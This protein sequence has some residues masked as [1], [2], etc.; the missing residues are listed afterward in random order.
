[1]KETVL[2]LDD[3]DD[4]LLVFQHTFGAAYD[5]RVAST[6]GEARRMLAERPADIVISDQ[7]MPE[8]E[9]TDFLREVAEIYPQSLRALMTGSVHLG[10]V[11]PEV[12]AGIVQLFIA[13]PWTGQ[14]VQQ[15]LE[16]AIASCRLH[17]E[18]HS[19]GRSMLE[20]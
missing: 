9:G 16:R 8:I 1:M 5:V 15:M 20:E 14:N 19:G 12:G 3:D 13:K 2:Y 18:M 11:L 10:W 17:Q 4:C 7:T 6:P